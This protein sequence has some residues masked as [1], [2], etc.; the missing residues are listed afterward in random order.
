M[1]PGRRLDTLL[2]LGSIQYVK[3]SLHTEPPAS[4]LYGPATG[5]VIYEYVWPYYG[6]E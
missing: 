4:C 5:L 2:R 1:C 3:Q 6:Q